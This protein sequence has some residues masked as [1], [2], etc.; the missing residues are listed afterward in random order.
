MYFY[1]GT[2]TVRLVNTIFYDG[3]EDK[4][5]IKGL[6]LAFSV[7]LRE[8]LHN[9]HVR[10]AGEGGGIWAEPVQPLLLQNRNVLPEQLAGK[11]VNLDQLP[12]RS[13]SLVKDFP[14][15]NDF[16][17]VQHNADGFNISKRTNTRS[18]W[19]DAN[20][21]KRAQGFVFV[22]DSKGGIGVG[23]KDF[24]QSY[25]AAVEVRNAAEDVAEMKIWLWSPYGEAMDMRHYDTV[26][27]GLA[28]VYEDVQPGLSTPYG[29]ARTS[30]LMLFPSAAI[31]SNQELSNEG[32]LAS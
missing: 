3:E 23:L 21:G 15:W 12:A 20:A 10:F 7:P 8:A 30:E 4:D 14:V 22:G 29:I 24:W 6:G 1:Q 25:P 17:L 13:Q 16:K 19:L 27:H 2:K 31:P 9:R 32:L 5:F 26:G 11:P 28:A 18:T